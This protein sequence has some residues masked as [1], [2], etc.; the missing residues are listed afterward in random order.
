[1]KRFFDTLILIVIAFL[2]M[3]FILF[4]GLSSDPQKNWDS[5]GAHEKQYEALTESVSTGHIGLGE[6]PADFLSEMDNP[7]D[8]I[9][10][11]IAAA[12]NDSYAL[13][14]VAYYN[15]KYYVYFGLTPELL[16]FLPVKLLTG[17]TVPTWIC[18]IIMAVL[19]VPM[20]YVFC[21]RLMRR[22]SLCSFGDAGPASRPFSNTLLSSLWL[23]LIGALGLP[24]LAAFCT[25][26][27]VPSVTGLFLM[28][29]GLS[30]FLSAESANGQISKFNLI[31]GSI[32]L[33]LTIG[34]RPAMS[35]SFLLL[36]AIFAGAIKRG[37]FFRLRRGSAA[38]TLCVLIPAVLTALPFLVYNKL[39]FGSPFDFGYRYLLTTKDLLHGSKTAGESLT[40]AW[41]LSL[42][43]PEL[44][45]SFPFM[46]ISDY[47]GPYADTLY[48]EPLFGG[49]FPLHPFII[50][51]I[52]MLA[53][54]C[55]AGLFRKGHAGPQSKISEG[56][57]A[58]AGIASGFSNGLM[59]VISLLIGFIILTADSV[60]AGVSQRYSSDFALFFFIPAM[61]GICLTYNALRKKHP[62]AASLLVFITVLFVF[63]E[64]FLSASS[65]LCDERYFAMKDWNPAVYERLAGWLGK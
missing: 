39:R 17:R 16:V 19:C 4:C 7:Y 28:L 35:L 26:Y 32:L 27:S 58:G 23:L 10:R 43:P 2:S 51:G 38:N 30:V 37:D 55:M 45:A 61:T 65:I 54:M 47:T 25:T 59:A 64:I 42:S 1:M 22:I 6:R 8:P 46:H 29:A 33:S 57:A 14:D 44:T 63:I 40:S 21:S 41:L 12:E 3:A 9:E 34:C 31:T 60:I 48:V 18:D 24:Y 15:D 5:W 36:F 11:S 20:A 52:V 62:I 49:L 13:I 53:V 56:A 50:A